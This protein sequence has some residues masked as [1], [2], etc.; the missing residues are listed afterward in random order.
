MISCG[1]HSC[2]CAHVEIMWRSCVGAFVPSCTC[3]GQRTMCASQVFSFTV[4]IPG[5]VRLGGNFS[6]ILLPSWFYSS[7]LLTSSLPLVAIR[8][9]AVFD[10][11]CGRDMVRFWNSLSSESSGGERGEQRIL[12]YTIP[13]VEW[14][15]S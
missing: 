15:Q 6:A 3:G 8:I 9:R 7:W 13:D 1:V 12:I 5:T 4:W 11:R 2:R 14:Q 10:L